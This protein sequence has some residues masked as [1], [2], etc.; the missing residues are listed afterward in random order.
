MERIIGLHPTDRYKFKTKSSY[1]EKWAFLPDKERRNIIAS[2]LTYLEF[3]A[4]LKDNLKHVVPEQLE[5]ANWSVLVF[6]IDEGF[7]RTDILLYASVCEAALHTVLHAIYQKDTVTAHAALKRCYEKTEDSCV[8]L[9]VAHFEMQ[10][11]KSPTIGSL[12][13]RMSKTAGFRIRIKI[14][15]SYTCRRRGWSL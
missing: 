10:G 1:R 2:Q 13:L 4:W 7:H 11:A 15:H 6:D 8:P 12:C 5:A 14:C 9:N 3:H